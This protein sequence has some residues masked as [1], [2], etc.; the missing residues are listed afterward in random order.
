MSSASFRNSD[1]KKKVNF[2]LL[3]EFWKT[4]QIHWVVKRRGFTA[5]YFMGL[6]FLREVFLLTLCCASAKKLDLG[7]RNQKKNNK[8][9]PKQETKNPCFPH[10]VPVPACK[11]HPFQSIW[12]IYTDRCSQSKFILPTLQVVWLSSSSHPKTM[13]LWWSITEPGLINLTSQ[14]PNTTLW[15][16][17]ASGQDEVVCLL[18]AWTE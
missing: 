7:K 4:P 8:M 5:T 9:K 11:T 15:S 17:V 12:H 2:M 3:E 16:S 18:R 14:E 1:I 13:W 10:V 6:L